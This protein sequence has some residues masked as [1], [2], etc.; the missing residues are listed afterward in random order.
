[1]TRRRGSLPAASLLAGALL[2]T[3]GCGDGT[4]AGPTVP[5]VP[6]IDD[7]RDTRGQDPCALLDAEQ[8]AR[9]DLRPPGA[10]TRVAEGP[11]CEWGGGAGA[12]SLAVTLYHDGGGLQTLARNS[13]PSTARVRIEGYPALETFTGRGEFCQYDVGVAPNQVV[14]ASMDNGVPDSCTALQS[15][16]PVILADLPPYQG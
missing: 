5:P 11:R 9:F 1:M 3:T 4:Q 16:L 7:A 10:A 6:P 8:L 14:M 13:E 2:F 12:T 15:V